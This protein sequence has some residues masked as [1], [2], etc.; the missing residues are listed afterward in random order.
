MKTMEWISIIWTQ[1]FYFDS[2]PYLH[3]FI[4]DHRIKVLRSDPSLAYPEPCLRFTP[5]PQYLYNVGGRLNLHAVHWRRR[6]GH[7]YRVPWKIQFSHLR[8]SKK[9]GLHRIQKMWVASIIYYKIVFYSCPYLPCGGFTA[10][11]IYIH[12]F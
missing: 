3:K 8:R 12:R 5:L 6:Y 11:F 4:T 10:V 2:D 9:N 7:R 1:I